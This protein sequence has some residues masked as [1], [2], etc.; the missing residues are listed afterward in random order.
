M[1]DAV[2]RM[3]SPAEKERKKADKNPCSPRADIY[4]ELST[5]KMHNMRVAISFIWGKMRTAAWEIALQIA[6][7]D[8]SKD[9]VGGGQHIRFW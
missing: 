3:K 2:L 4:E 6:L 9:G 7:R 1:S 8:C 5:K